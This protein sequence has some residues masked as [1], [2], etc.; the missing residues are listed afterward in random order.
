MGRRFTVT[1][2]FFSDEM[3]TQYLRGFGYEVDDGN[4]KLHELVDQWIAEGRAREGG[5]AST[6]SGIGEAD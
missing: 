4:D 6:I 5:P 2:D 3:Q 1:Q